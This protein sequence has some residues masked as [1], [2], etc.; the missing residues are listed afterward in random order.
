MID[1]N[2]LRIKLLHAMDIAGVLE[3]KNGISNDQFNKIW[4]EFSPSILE[5]YK[6]EL[7]QL[8]EIVYNPGGRYVLEIEHK[9]RPMI[10]CSLVFSVIALLLNV[11]RYIA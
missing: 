5:G 8:E 7:R 6:N 1:Y 2:A 11:L 10:L 4:D 3:T 9:V